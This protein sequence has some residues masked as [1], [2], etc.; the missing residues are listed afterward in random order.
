MYKKQDN[1]INIKISAIQCNH[2][3]SHMV[4]VIQFLTLPNVMYSH[5][6]FLYWGIVRKEG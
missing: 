2:G 4:Y 6:V 1:K 5:S 3:L